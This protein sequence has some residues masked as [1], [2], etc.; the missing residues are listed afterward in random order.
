M[1]CDSVALTNPSKHAVTVRLYAADAYNIADGGAFAF[2]AFKDKPKGVGTWIKL[3]V[4]RVTVPAGRA[5][6]IPI[7]VQVPTNVTPGDM[8][9]GVVARDTKVRQGKSVG[10]VNVGVR[11]GVGVRLYAQVAGL[12]HPKLSLTKLNLQLQGGL[13]SRLVRSRLRDRELPGRQ[14]GQRATLRRSRAARSRR[15][16]GRSTLAKHQFAELLPGSQPVVVTEK[17][18]GT[19][20]GQPDRPRARQGHGHRRWSEARSPARS[21]C[22]GCPGCRFSAW[23]CC[24]GCSAGAWRLR[25]SRVAHAAAAWTGRGCRHRGAGRHR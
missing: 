19:A 1:I 15:A 3:P 21:P 24:S 17:V 16:P 18:T 6:D 5:A 14:R 2:T 13:R 9:G 7:V 12:R 22:G 8:A 4:T 11:A 10:G 25:R 20:L 23:S